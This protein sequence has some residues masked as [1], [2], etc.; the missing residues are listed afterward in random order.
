[1]PNRINDQHQTADK[2]KVFA[3]LCHNDNPP[4]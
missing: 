4:R 2:H 1:M 3:I